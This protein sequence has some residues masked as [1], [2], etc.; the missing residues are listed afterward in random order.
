MGQFDRQSVPQTGRSNAGRLVGQKGVLLSTT[1]GASGATGATGRRE[2]SVAGW[3]PSLPPAG[4]VGQKKAPGHV[5]DRGLVWLLGNCFLEGRQI[6]GGN[7]HLDLGGFVAG[8]RSIVGQL[9]V[10]GLKGFPRIRD[11][12]ELLGRNVLGGSDV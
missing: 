10:V 8:L 12:I 3:G 11:V 9:G 7:F 1:T 5:T 2:I 4:E 6:K